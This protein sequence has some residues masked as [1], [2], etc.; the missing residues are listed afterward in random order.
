MTSFKAVP[1]AAMLLAAGTT[2]HAANAGSDLFID[3]GTLAHW[4]S[5]QLSNASVF[6]AA[7]SLPRPGAVHD[8]LG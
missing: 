7:G 4:F 6:S 3:A 8:L 2:L 5:E 1:L